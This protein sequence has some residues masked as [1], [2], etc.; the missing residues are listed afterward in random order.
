MALSNRQKP[1]VS[2]DDVT[3]EIADRENSP[4]FD[5][6]R[7]DFDQLSDNDEIDE[8]DSEPIN[9]EDGSDNNPV[10]DF[11]KRKEKERK[12]RGAKVNGESS[13]KD[14][15]E[16]PDDVPT[17]VSPKK[18][19]R[20]NRLRNAFMR[21]GPTAGI[22]GGLVG[23]FGL[24]SIVLGPA[25]LLVNLS[26]LLANH[27][28]H[29]NRVFVKTGRSYIAAVLTGQTRNCAESKIKC[30]FA[31][32]SESRLQQ[33]RERG[34]TV[35]IGDGQKNTL[36]RYKVRGLEYKGTK[37]TNIVDYKGLRYTHPQF[38]SLLKRFPVKAGYINAKSSFNKTLTKFGLNVS[39]RFRSSKSPDKETREAENRE[40][41]N[42]Q[43][44]ANVDADG[45][46]DPDRTR[47]AVNSESERANSG[48]KDRLSGA[49]NAAAIA[50]SVSLPVLF[51]CTGY[52]IIRATQAAIT[53][54]WHAELLKFATPFLKPGAELKEA[55]DGGNIDWET[56][57][58]F[59][60]RLTRPVTQKEADADPNDNI[61]NDMV[62]KTAMDS[63]GINAALNGD[64][65]QNADYTAW[66][67]NVTGIELVREAQ[68]T[69]GKENIRTACNA[70]R[71][72]SYASAA[73]CVFG[74]WAIVKCAA[75]VGAQQLIANIWGDDIIKAVSDRL[76]EPAI[77]AI[78][79]ANLTDNLHG[80]ALGDALVSASGVIGGNMD[81]SSGFA[82]AGDDAQAYQAYLDMLNDKDY[83]D[84]L[85]ADAKYEASK[86][87]LNPNNPYSFAGQFA[88]GVST[89]A[90]N[91]TGFSVLSNMLGSVASI[92]KIGVAHAAKDGLFMPIQIYESQATFQAALDKC[93]DPGL[94]ELDIPCANE[95]GRA[96]PYMLPVVEE[97]M[98]SEANG[99][100]RVC[101]DEAI[102][103]L[104]AQK[105]EDD[106]K[107]E[108]QPF[109]DRDTGKP[110]G[111]NKYSAEEK[112]YK[113]P[114]LMFMRHC[115]NDREYPLGYTDTS[116]EEDNED[117]Y[118]GAE[119]AA[120][121]GSK[122]NDEQLAWM[123]YYYHMCIAL[124]ASEENIEY[125]WEDA[126]TQTATTTTCGIADTSTLGD[127]ATGNSTRG[128][129]R[130]ILV[131]TT[132]GDSL[133]GM[134]DALLAGGNSYHVAIEESGMAHRLVPDNQIANGARGANTDSLNIALVGFADK[135]ARLDASS[136]QN[137]TLSK[138]IAEWSSKF[139]IPTEKVSGAGILNGGSTRGVAGHI[140]VA[141]AAGYNDRTDPGINF[142]WSEV[143]ANAK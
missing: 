60:D 97:C 25:S 76:Q 122:I 58:Y 127:F 34:I 91:G 93:N 55:G 67:P 74:P 130:M 62:G 66:A 38:N 8:E 50:S 116:V 132:E 85:I 64:P 100:Q 135:G 36:G 14:E 141:Q 15:E 99:S 92:P 72:A 104:Y 4:E 44:G 46:T 89:M 20:F 136:P 31:T 113:N 133:Q 52:D 61:T 138:C 68:E 26:D 43:T 7:G 120:G 108:P 51:A 27:S 121:K 111:M 80:P 37:V 63:K 83:Q 126:P 128:E 28:D 2:D 5:N 115:G 119:C 12:K 24:G 39:D 137:Q 84:E 143:L 123:S 11:Y 88:A 35:D 13:V 17:G 87:Q 102:D 95:S 49:K 16:N 134:A 53:L 70:A 40:R 23:T 59:G 41:M 6:I 48:A 129:P 90:W 78:T 94:G 112:E 69:I 107:E 42:S 30:K 98:E 140:D 73:Q 47:S 45:N 21:G 77:E 106:D 79:K 18:L 105:Y 82:A 110:T 9:W 103:Y 54:Y 22:I 29:G 1:S 131:H 117:W 142:P 81:R 10:E 32:I 19:N 65:V 139:N 56:V 57:E 71:I 118:I 96:I 86:D 125:C 3:R 109:I 101:I 75:A 124:Y 114:F 33:W